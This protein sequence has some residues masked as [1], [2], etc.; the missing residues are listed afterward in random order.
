MGVH[1][2]TNRHNHK[3]PLEA[4]TD[5]PIALESLAMTI[6]NDERCRGKLYLGTSEKPVKFSEARSQH[7]LSLSTNNW[8]SCR[9]LC[10][11]LADGCVR[12]ICH[13]YVGSANI[14]VFTSY[15]DE[16]VILKLLRI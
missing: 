15:S 14:S 1:S 5:Y 12:F 4:G 7:E 11:R 2:S 6:Q 9:I 3:E 8:A 10:R 13:V 16:E